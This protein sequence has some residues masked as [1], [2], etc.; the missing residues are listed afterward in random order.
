MKFKQYLNLLSERYINL[1]TPEEKKPYV[2]IVKQ[3]LP[4]D[5]IQPIDDY[6]YKRKI[7]ND[8][9][10]KIALGNPNAKKIQ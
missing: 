6:Y 5:D 2:D 4:N 1:F 3:K 9:I 7:G 10:T 8:W